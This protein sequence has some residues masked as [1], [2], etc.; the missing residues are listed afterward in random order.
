MFQ[1]HIC[2]VTVYINRELST[3]PNGFFFSGLFYLMLPVNIFKLSRSGAKEKYK[4]K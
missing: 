2:K 4:L 3:T 1:C